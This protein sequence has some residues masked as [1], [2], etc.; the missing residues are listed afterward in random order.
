VIKF[1]R[2]LQSLMYFLQFENNL[3][4]EP[5]TNKFFWKTAKTLLDE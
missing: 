2:F 1:E 4:V 3:V 5:G